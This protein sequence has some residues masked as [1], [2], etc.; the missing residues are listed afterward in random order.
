MAN[1]T[2]L[3]CQ[4]G[5]TD[6]ELVGGRGISSYHCLTYEAQEGDKESEMSYSLTLPNYFIKANKDKL[7]TGTSNICIVNGAAIRT[8]FGEPDVVV[9]P[10]GTSIR[11]V[12]DLSRQRRNL[13]QIGTHS[14]LVV[15][16]STPT[17]TLPSDAVVLANTTFGIGGQ[18]YSMAS[19]YSSCSAG[20]LQFVP[21]QGDNIVNGVLEL[22]LPQSITGVSV[23]NL[24][25][26][27]V[28]R[29]KALTG[30]TDLTSQFNHVL[31]CVPN[32]TLSA[33]NGTKGW[34]AF[35]YLPGYF[36]FYNHGETSLCGSVFLQPRRQNSFK[37]N[38]FSHVIVKQLGAP[39]SVP[40][41]TK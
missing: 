4:V 13:A 1:G 20:K 26:D 33:T 38:I 5:L 10:K 2:C 29:T 12:G 36:S 40:K 22:Q 37:P 8:E 17:E 7:D 6:I 35:A 32:G 18:Q 30:V 41:C 16:I 21:G 25:N 23:R 28:T 39:V 14:V 34:L 9:I 31:F 3:Y 11:F 19:Q 15:R 27:F 24:E